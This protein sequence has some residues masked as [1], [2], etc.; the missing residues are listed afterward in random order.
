[1]SRPLHLLTVWNPSYT[2]D[3]MHGHIKI[4]LKLAEKSRKSETRDDDVYVWW[5]KILSRSRDQKKL[6]HIDEIL[7]I[8][9]QI[10]EGTE[11]H[12]Y[13]TDYR[14]L[15]VAWLGGITTRN[16]H[17]DEGEQSHV[18]AYYRE[19]DFS[20]DCW[21][22]LK[23]IRRIVADDTL[24]VIEMLKELKNTQFD[25]KPVSL[26]GGMI[27]TPLIVARERE[28]LWFASREYLTGG[29]FWAEYDADRSGP[30]GRL[31]QDLRDNLFGRRNWA[32]LEV[33]SRN[34]FATAEAVYRSARET[35]HFDFSPAVVEYCKAVE[36]ELNT[37]FLSSFREKLSHLPPK[38][39]VTTIHQTMEINLVDCIDH[40]TVGAIIAF[41]KRDARFKSCV[42][43]ALPNDQG[44]L[45]GRL[46]GELL[47][48]R[49]LR[50][51]AAHEAK[52]NREEVEEVRNHLLGIGCKGLMSE[53][54]EI[55]MKTL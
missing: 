48:L 27:N 24:E 18:P 35:T 55:K 33:T 50:N 22:R 8:Q 16:V 32:A 20:F 6:S 25:D 52:L 44:W 36:V 15:Y 40:F 2:S 42:K 17:E 54:V 47:A 53:I 26:Y 49:D 11:T 28:Q 30:T 21:F 1:M 31:A 45:L 5:G 41:L 23:D 37:L 46:P 29:A 19:E 38:D 14:S 34:F 3:S 43:L 51:R 4:V 9:N 12:L 39:T 13:L 7:A 10:Q